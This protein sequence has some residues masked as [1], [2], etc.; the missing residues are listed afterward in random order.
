MHSD[1]I[2]ICVCCSGRLLSLS[3]VH[4]PWLQSRAA[5]SWE[6]TPCKIT[7][8][9]IETHHGDDGAT[10]SAEFE[11]EYE[12]EGQKLTGDRYSFL[13]FSSSRSLAKSLIEKYPKGSQQVCYY[14]PEDH[15]DVVLSR[16]ND[17]IVVWFI[18]LPIIFIVVGIG[19]MLAGTGLFSR[20]G[21][22][23]ISQSLN[24]SDAVSS[25]ELSSGA[26]SW[27]A[28]AKVKDFVAKDRSGN[29][30]Y[31][32]EAD[33]SDVEWSPPRKLKTSDSRL[34][35][36]VF[37]GFFSL[38]WNGILTFFFYDFIEDGIKLEFASIFPLLFGIPFFLVGLGMLG[39]LGYLF[40]SLFNPKVEIAI[41]TGAVPIGQEVDIAWEVDGNSQRIRKLIIE[42]HGTQ[43]VRYV[44]GTD[45]V[46]DEQ[47]FELINVAEVDDPIQIA[48]G[49]ATVQIPG[50]TMHTFEASNNQVVWSVNV[51][52]EIPW[53]PDVSESFSFRVTP[54]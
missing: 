15:S 7:S 2:R 25:S 52:G 3:N 17:N 48:F 13:S 29:K 21:G 11:Y 4:F 44:R 45:T 16:D 43:Q 42:I 22:N 38:F 14:N 18:F 50:D 39:F 5:Q 10:Y 9:K 6:S 33:Q 36:L 49:R 35:L 54:G 27:G 40:L 51:R 47:I 1:P 20:G 8:A 28:D 32:F 37:L 24:S 34:G 26:P 31:L 12:V 53:A 30:E 46:T 19:I 23:A 41:G